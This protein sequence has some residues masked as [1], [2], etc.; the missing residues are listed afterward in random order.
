M[1]AE[2]LVLRGLA[3]LAQHPFVVQ[4]QYSAQ[5]LRRYH[6]VM[7]EHILF[8][9]KQ[10]LGVDIGLLHE[11]VGFGSKLP[12]VVL[13]CEVILGEGLRLSG[14]PAAELFGH[15]EVLEIVVV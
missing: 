11:S 4:E 10:L 6:D 1:V 15:G 9:L 5:V 13:D 14:L 2:V 12:W 7:V 3:D 8:C